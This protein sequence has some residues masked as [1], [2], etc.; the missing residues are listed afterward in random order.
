MVHTFCANREG[1][2][3]LPEVQ[4]IISRYESFLGS[5]CQADFGQEETLLLSLKALGKSS[6]QSS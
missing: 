6:F 3:S 2:F 5:Q 4:A 1:C